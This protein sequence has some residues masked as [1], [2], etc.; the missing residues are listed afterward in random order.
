MPKFSDLSVL[1]QKYF[2]DQLTETQLEQFELAYNGYLEWNQ[3]INVI[4]RKDIENL[5]ERHFLHSLAIAK[6]I[7]FAPGTKV[8]DVG[9]GGG[10]P[11]VPL[12]IFFPEV[13]FHLVD[14]MRKK[15]HVVQEI[16][17]ISGVKNVYYSI[18]Q[19][20]E[21]EGKFDF[22]VSRAVARLTKFLPWVREKIHCKGKNE[23]A[24]GIL[25]L[26]GGNLEEELAEVN[27][28]IRGYTVLRLEDWFD[29]SFF[30]TKALLHIPFCK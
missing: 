22:V 10:F 24:N 13:E 15:I 9:T 30:S 2:P 16:V 19:A 25:Y 26:K 6:A 4:S 5:A 7:S 11:G 18:Q 14:T 12:A 17:H 20:S 3:K 1:F 27:K 23:V 29:E 21:V 8:L 28:E